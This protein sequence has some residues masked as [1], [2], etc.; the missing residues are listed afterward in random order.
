MP[1]SSNFYAISSGERLSFLLFFCLDRVFLSI[2]FLKCTFSFGGAGSSS[3]FSGACGAFCFY[4][5]LRA[6][7]FSFRSAIS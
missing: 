5:S 4:F 7:F 2:R 3:D 6:R 1:F